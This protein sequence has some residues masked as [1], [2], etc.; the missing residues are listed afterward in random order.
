[1]AIDNLFATNTFD[2]NCR[3][4][5]VSSGLV[6]D[7]ITASSGVV[8]SLSC[9][10]VDVS[11]TT[12]LNNLV[13]SGDIDLCNFTTI[14]SY[15]RNMG[16]DDYNYDIS[17]G[18][19][20][21]PILTF[22]AQG[23]IVSSHTRYNVRISA[24]QTTSF[25]GIAYVRGWDATPCTFTVNAY[26]DDTFSTRSGAMVRVPGNGT[27]WIDSSDGLL[28]QSANWNNYRMIMFSYS[29]AQDGTTYLSLLSPTEWTT[30]WTGNLR[31]ITDNVSDLG[32]T[33]LRWRDVYATNATIQTSDE[34]DKTQI[35]DLDTKYGLDFI[36]LLSPKEFKWKEN[37]SNRTH[38]GLIAQ[39]VESVLVN[40]LGD[41]VDLQDTAI[42]IKDT[43]IEEDGISEITKYG[44]RYI[45]LIPSLI[46]SIQQLDARLSALEV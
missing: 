41:G 40:G 12:T 25:I 14:A 27:T 2:L 28:V 15:N 16:G 36:K 24:L 33:L 29:K 42:V 13:V 31:P 7:D 30:A 10:D 22:T 8:S 9:E 43:H 19:K 1:M 45:E 5:D 38:H 46:K 3:T 11:G 34:N 18:S 39:E 6:C 32:T 21:D 37:E 26:L 44:L 35:T 20:V 17:S 23:N 4:L